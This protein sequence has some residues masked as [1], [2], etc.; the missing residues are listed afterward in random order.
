MQKAPAKRE[1]EKEGRE[2]GK[3]GR[4][5]GG[6][7]RERERE[8]KKERKKRKKTLESSYSLS[9]SKFIHLGKPWE[10]MVR[11]TTYKLGRETSPKTKS[12]RNVGLGLYN[13]QKYMKINFY[14]L[15][16][17]ICGIYLL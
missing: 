3:E 2:G 9:L 8:R 11:A 1:R 5:E 10:D 17:I 4:R 15:T 14:C 16:H 6:R 13:F 12:C 7:E